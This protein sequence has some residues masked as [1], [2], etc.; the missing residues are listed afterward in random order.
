M[1]SYDNISM[2]MVNEAESVIYE[3][4]PHAECV[5]TV[6]VDDTLGDKV[7]VTIVAKIP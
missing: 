7:K 6:Q 3:T 2:H 4:A 1:G 5:F